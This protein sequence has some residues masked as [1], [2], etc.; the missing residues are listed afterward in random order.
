[1]SLSQVTPW[2]QLQNWRFG[3]QYANVQI[4][5]TSSPGQL[6]Y[7]GALATAGVNKIVGQGNLAGKAALNRIQAKIAAKNGVRF[8]PATTSSTTA[9]AASQSATANASASSILAGSVVNIFA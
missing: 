3:Q 7:S 5:G 9:I 6:D 1:V 2:Q 4:F 8:H